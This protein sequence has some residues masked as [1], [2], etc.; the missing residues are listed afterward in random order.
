MILKNYA[1]NHTKKI[2][3]NYVKNYMH[4]S[5]CWLVTIWHMGLVFGV[6]FWEVM[7]MRS[8][9]IAGASCEAVAATGRAAT[10]NLAFC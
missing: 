3:K 4:C 9:C 10:A 6:W 7:G 8:F 1:K 5:K 2:K